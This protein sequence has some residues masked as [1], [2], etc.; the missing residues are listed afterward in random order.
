MLSEGDSPAMYSLI[1]QHGDN[2]QLVRVPPYCV[3]WTFML[4]KLYGCFIRGYLSLMTNEERTYNPLQ[5]D[6]RSRN[7][8]PLLLKQKAK[9]IRNIESQQSCHYTPYK[10]A[11]GDICKHVALNSLFRIDEM[12]CQ[13]NRSSVIHSKMCPMQFK[14][15]L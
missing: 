8:G 7:Y 12:V 9:T 3:V 10:L 6:K 4:D 13:Y 1:S 11:I 14:L 5:I 2:S 15:V